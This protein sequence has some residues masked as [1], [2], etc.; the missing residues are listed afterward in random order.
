MPK[1]GVFYEKAIRDDGSLF[2]PQRL[3]HDF[4]EEQKRRL[5]SY[6][7]ANQYLNEIIPL[8][9]RRFK[10][11]WLRYYRELPA[12]SFTFAFIDPAIS[13]A[14]SADFSGITVVQT[15]VNQLWYVRL[16][17]RRKITP[18]EIVDLVF[19]L[20]NQFQCQAIGIED[21]A[22]QKALLYMIHEEALRRGQFPPVKG[23]KPGTDKT[24][25]TRILGLVPRFEWGRIFLAHGMYDFEKEFLEFPRS[26]HDDILDSLSQIEQI[27]FYP[28][29]ERTRDDI[30]SIEGIPDPNAPGYESA[31]IRK[32]L[33][34]A[35]QP[36]DFE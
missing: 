36:Q 18:T 3:T 15:D 17:E 14:D 34:E 20:H 6:I 8:E 27:A 31:Y 1:W 21:V 33:K 4:L 9:D 24:K 5:G 7:F 29:R 30:P 22:Y 35:N 16:A 26:S 32:L 10:P 13:Q 28:E 19:A 25:E 12:R 11:E 2:F 23:I